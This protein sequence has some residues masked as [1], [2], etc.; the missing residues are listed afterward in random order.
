M[1]ADVERYQR[2]LREARSRKVKRTVAIAT[3]I[4]IVVPGAFYYRAKKK[5]REDAELTAS[6]AEYNAPVPAADIAAARALLATALDRAQTAAEP[7]IGA[8][9]DAEERLAPHPEL[10]P[11][12][13]DI[14]KIPPYELMKITSTDSGKRTGEPRFFTSLRGD[15]SN[16]DYRASRK[17]FKG[18]KEGGVKLIADTKKKV[19]APF[20]KFDLALYIDLETK[21]KAAGGESFQGGAVM[22]TAFLYDYE[23]RKIECAAHFAA[24]SSSSLKLF[25]HSTVETAGAVDMMKNALELVQATLVRVGPAPRDEV[26]SL[27]TVVKEPKAVHKGTKPNH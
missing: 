1:D 7:R 14:S 11:C 4:A 18:G 22:G 20:P 17:D 2:E 5:E 25:E 27:S 6:V 10:G 3:A 12:P 26:P 19:E 24:T 15:L 16:F 8:V 21:A 23:T 9:L 13:R